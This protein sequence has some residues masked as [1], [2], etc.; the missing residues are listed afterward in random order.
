MQ[1][2]ETHGIIHKSHLRTLN[3]L[4]WFLLSLPKLGIA[5]KALHR[6]L[7]LSRQEVGLQRVLYFVFCL[8]IFCA[9]AVGDIVHVKLGS[10]FRYASGCWVNVTCRCGHVLEFFNLQIFRLFLHYSHSCRPRF[11]CR[12]WPMALFECEKNK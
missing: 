7:L 8:L 3:F 9:F 4:N 2:K 10:F 6:T 1:A 11:V 5:P 12:I